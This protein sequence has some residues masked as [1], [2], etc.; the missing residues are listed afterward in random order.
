MTYVHVE[1]VPCVYYRDGDGPL[2]T[3]PTVVPMRAGLRFTMAQHET[4]ARLAWDIAQRHGWPR[5]ERWR[6]NTRLLGHEDITPLSR[7]DGNGGWDP[8]AL[9]EKPY[10]DWNFV[11]NYLE[12]LQGGYMPTVASVST[13]MPRSSPSGLRQTFIDRFL[14]LIR[15]GQENL[16]VTHAIRNGET[17]PNQLT[18]LVFFARH[19]EFNGQPIR[20]EDRQRV[21]EW[22]QIRDKI[23]RPA[24]A[25]AR[26]PA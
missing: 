11:Y 5:N 20:V 9:R 16:A 12:R 15:A 17:D 22:L 10:F 4:V 25:Q 2:I 18:N 14:Q 21:Q 3:D 7:H 13:V 26:W 6:L 23:V 19:P 1:C 8:G 24:L